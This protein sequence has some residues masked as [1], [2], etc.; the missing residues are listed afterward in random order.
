M[1]GG[2]PDISIIVPIYGVEH[3]LQQCIDSIRRQTYRNLEI[4]LVDDGSP[5]DCGK[6]CD[7][8][9]I[10]DARIIVIHKENEG[11]SCARNSGLDTAKGKYVAFVDADDEIHPRYIEILAG[12]CEQYGCDIAQC[13]FLAVAEDSVKL[14]LNPQYSLG[15]YSGRQAVEELCRSS[16]AVK[17][18]VAW[19]KLYDRR[20]FEGIRYPEGKIHEDEFLTCQLLWRARKIVVTNQYLYYYLQRKDSI[21]GRPF[22]VKRLDGLEAFRERLDF[23]DRQGLE[24]AYF[25]TL[26]KY[27]HLIEKDYK[28]LLENVAGSEDICK[29]LLEEKESIEKQFPGLLQKSLATAREDAFIQ[30]KDICFCPEDAK[31]MLYGAGKWGQIYYRRISEKYKG[32]IAGW[33]DNLWYV[34]TQTDI[35]VQPLDLLVRASY[36][37]VLIAI[38]QETV[39]EEVRSN[40]EGWGIAKEKILSIPVDE[41]HGK[42]YSE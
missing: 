38:R 37:F 28:L 22:H 3:Y 12:M 14:P 2:E 13:D 5:D 29:K 15:F 8:N 23:L 25:A 4:I 40:L 10:K 32:M 18:S 11:L 1:W 42:I 30:G 16:E 24:R 17:Y 36:D 21:M 35:P 7:D 27:Y 31:V 19:N 34:M 41:P 6:I 33:V 9:S 20:L 39:Q 26:H